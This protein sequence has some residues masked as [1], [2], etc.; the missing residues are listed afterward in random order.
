MESNILFDMDHFAW[1]KTEDDLDIHWDCNLRQF[2]YNIYGKYSHYCKKC[3]MFCSITDIQI[4]HLLCEDEHIF[5]VINN[6]DKNIKP[7][8]EDFLD[9]INDDEENLNCSQENLINTAI[10]DIT[11][12]S[13]FAPFSKDG[14]S[15]RFTMI[16]DTDTDNT[17]NFESTH[18]NIKN[19]ILD[20]IN[21]KQSGIV[22]LCY[23]FENFKIYESIIVNYYKKFKIL[24]VFPSNFIL[25]WFV[26]NYISQNLIITDY[27]I[28]DDSDLEKNKTFI[29]SNSLVL[30]TYKNINKLK[31]VLD[32][33]SLVL[34]DE[35]HY[36]YNKQVY[37]IILN[38]NGSVIY[39]SEIKHDKHNY[40]KCPEIYN[41]T[42]TD[43]FVDGFYPDLVM[44]D[45][46]IICGINSNISNEFRVLKSIADIISKYN[47]KR[48]LIFN[49]VTDLVSEKNSSKRQKIIKNKIFEFTKQRYN[50]VEIPYRSSDIEKNEC[51][52]DFNS[53]EYSILCNI[54][55]IN[56][57]IIFPNADMFIF[58]T[59]NF[60][61]N[62]I[63][64]NL[65]KMLNYCGTVNQEFD[66]FIPIFTN[67]NSTSKDEFEFDI[68][69][70]EI[71][72]KVM[73]SLKFIDNRLNNNNI[74]NTKYTKYETQ[75]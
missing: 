38:L 49:K 50:I 61:Q 66:L 42:S 41:I 45:Y 26:T 9:I 63:I 46:N 74:K 73:I 72:N 3:N 16:T 8:M 60:S 75:N 37:K 48:I 12:T 20:K 30:C 51:W 56:E 19:K 62:L 15:C 71:I 31:F 32:C 24:L 4:N 1:I 57:S 28:Y 58:L 36:I 21:L 64:E 2:D 39:F 35:A 11:F 7:S 22:N 25:N 18:K 68:K 70:Q 67:Q 13:S 10:L 17:P 44:S 40:T 54:S 34:L 47:K 59:E 5:D 29:S 33:F 27:V 52:D 6:D 55:D 53:T 23:N 43:I 65:F 14:G 69:Y